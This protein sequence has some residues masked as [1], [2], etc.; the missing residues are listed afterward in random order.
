MRAQGWGRIVNVASIAG[1][2]GNANMSAPYSASKAAVIALTKS[3]GKEL[4]RAGV[5]RG[6]L[7]ECVSQTPDRPFRIRAV[8]LPKLRSLGATISG[9]G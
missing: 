6:S 4:A 7:R 3:A 1:V 8:E 9:P 5:A 2:E